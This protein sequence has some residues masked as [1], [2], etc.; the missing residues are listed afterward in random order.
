MTPIQHFLDFALDCAW[1][2]GRISLGHFQTGVQ[3]ERK[4]D[5]SPVTIADRAVEQML[6]ERIT[7]TWPGH[8]IIG[9]EFGS[10]NGVGQY[11]WVLDPIDG[12]KSFAQGVPLY[13]NLIALTDPEGPLVGVAHYPALNEII[14]AAR[15]LGCYWNGRRCQ[16]STVDQ[17]ADAVLLTSELHTI[18]LPKNAPAWQSLV[19]KTYFQRTWGDAYGYAL[20]ATGRAEIMLE[21]HLEIWDAAPFP[22]IMQEA[23]GTYT[24]W[25]GQV[26]IRGGNALAT[27]GRLH[28]QAMEILRNP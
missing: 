27:N 21:P 26:D 1:K 23:G 19:S 7:R 6:R 28:A 24:D 16:V 14:Y 11:T 15:G 4:A 5:N 13:A 20:V 18:S 22:V 12:T 25:R 3:V 8:S 9:E 17:L 2:A 10:A